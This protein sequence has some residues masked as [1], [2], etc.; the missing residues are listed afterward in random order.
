MN[1]NYTFIAVFLF[2]GIG[3]GM[4][5]MSLLSSPIVEEKTVIVN[6]NPALESKLQSEIESNQVMSHMVTDV[7]NACNEKLLDKYNST[8]EKLKKR[9]Q[10]LSDALTKFRNT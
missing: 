2:M 9:N 5:T 4:S 10:I 8:E 7:I 1:R 6:A 3:I